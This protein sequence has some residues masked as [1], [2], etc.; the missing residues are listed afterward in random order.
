MWIRVLQAVYFK[1][2]I[3][4]LNRN[5]PLPTK[6]SLV[7]L[8]PFIDSQGLLRVGG[9]IRH[10]LLAYDEKHSAILSGASHLSRLVVEAC[11]RRTLHG[12]VQ[13]T[14]GLIRQTY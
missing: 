9:R 10:S 14:L 1:T 5:E 11:H 4:G 7:K 6:G 8:T 12:S 13:L 3:E 2:E